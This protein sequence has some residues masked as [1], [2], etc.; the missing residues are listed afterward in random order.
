MLRAPRRTATG[1]SRQGGPVARG[2]APPKQQAQRRWGCWGLPL[3]ANQN[4]KASRTGEGLPQFRTYGSCVTSRH[5]ERSADL[6]ILYPVCILYPVPYPLQPCVR[7]WP[8]IRD[9][10]LAHQSLLPS[11]LGTP[12]LF[13][14]MQDAMPKVRDFDLGCGKFVS[15]RNGAIS[16]VDVNNPTLSSPAQSSF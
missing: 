7:V 12:A 5:C 4:R 9:C 11:K 6:G 15:L 16:A 2:T 14:S 3:L 1:R 10:E 8:W 13:V